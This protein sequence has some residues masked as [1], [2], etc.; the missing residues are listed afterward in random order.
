MWYVKGAGSPPGQRASSEL[1]GEADLCPEFVDHRTR[2]VTLAWEG[3][4]MTGCL[5]LLEGSSGPV[6]HLQSL[7]GQSTERF[8]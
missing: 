5:E 2:C 8:L 7:G 6:L 3:L 4:K 1:Q